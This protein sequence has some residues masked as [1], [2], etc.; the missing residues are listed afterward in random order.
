[1]DQTFK[2]NLGQSFGCM[3]SEGIHKGTFTWN[4]PQVWLW[5]TLRN[6]R[7]CRAVYWITKII[8]LRL[9]NC[10]TTSIIIHLNSLLE[11]NPL[12][13]FRSSVLVMGVEQVTHSS[14]EI[15]HFM[16]S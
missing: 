7:L 11:L 12:G 16:I 2:Q 6:H 5:E 13:L 9:L 15:V 4:I 10:Q 3:T 1:M 14:S 8:L